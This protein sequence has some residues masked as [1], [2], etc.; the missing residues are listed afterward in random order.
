MASPVF[1]FL[2]LASVGLLLT[3][4]KTH[5]R[6]LRL[7]REREGVMDVEFGAE[8]NGAFVDAMWAR[9]RVRYWTMTPLAALV[10]GG[11]L[12][13]RHGLALAI[14]GALLWAPTLAFLVLGIVSA[15]RLARRE[16]HPET[17]WKRAATRGSRWWWGVDAGLVA[18]VAALTLASR[19]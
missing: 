9:D 7:E 14:V 5:G 11:S 13:L 1:L 16:P 4:A 12:F 2:I 6:A 18:L 17:S 8:T 15:L 10:M 3:A 19:A